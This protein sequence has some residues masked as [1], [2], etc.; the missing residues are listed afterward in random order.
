MISL[1]GFANEHGF[2]CFQAE[3][4]QTLGLHTWR[5]QGQIGGLDFIGAAHQNG[6]LDGMV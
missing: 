3:I 5:T 4:V 1:Q 2:D 6:P